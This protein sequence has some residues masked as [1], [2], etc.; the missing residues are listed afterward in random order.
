M[1]ENSETQC[2]KPEECAKPIFIA[3]QPIFDRERNIWG[4]EIFFRASSKALKAEIQD[5]DLAT[6]TVIVDGFPLASAGVEPSQRL[7]I[8]FT[9]NMVVNELY[10]SL[11]GGRCVADLPSRYNDQKF[12]QAC[13]KLKEQGFLLSAEVPAKSEVVRLVDII[14]IDVTRFEMKSL[15][16]S[17]QQLKSLNCM[18]LG[19]RVEEQSVYQLLQELDFDLFQGHLFS[20]PQLLPGSAPNLSRLAKLRLLKE[21]YNDEYST[22]D[23]TKIISSDVGLSYRLIRF[24]NSPYFGFGKK[25]TSIAHAVSLLGQM[26]LR[27]WLMAATLSNVSEGSHGRDIYFSCIKRARFLEQLAEKSSKQ[28]IDSQSLFLMGLFS[29][30]DLLLHQ[31]MESL[32]GELNLDEPIANALCGEENLYRCFLTLAEDI[33]QAKWKELPPQ[34]RELGLKAADVAVCHNMAV[35]WAAELSAAAGGKQ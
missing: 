1:T 34:L 22:A 20:K 27:Q 11:P 25:I 12:L 29:Q 33:E 35:L 4:H 30:L 31:P 28:R 14:R 26:P 17:A 10:A 21:L 15:I 24:I 16:N 2:L 5:P 3:R 6:A 8:N 19:Q 18:I 9:R 32:V 23:I 7:A 13:K